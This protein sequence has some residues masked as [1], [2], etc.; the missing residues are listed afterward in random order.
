MSKNS[1]DV[2]V[3]IGA[4][5]IG[6]AIAR[7]VGAGR[8]VMLADYSEDALK[9][10]AEQ[11]RTESFEVVTHTVD[12]SDPADVARLADDAAALGPVTRL[13]QAAGLSPVMASPEQILKVDLYGNA[14]VLEEF[15]RVVAPGGSGVVIA[16][17]AGHMIGA[18]PAEA[19][20]ALAFAPAAELLELPFL[21]PDK[22]TDSGL[23]YA[24]SKRANALR[25]R[26][27][28][29]AWGSGARGSTA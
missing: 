8:T 13:A 29:L 15:A 14:L 11:L 22:V 7:R 17:M 10:A 1:K 23:A 2:A 26:G 3:I 20:H 28:A 24:V 12:I 16:S 19:D 5:G 18:F 4:G 9:E 27:A 25:V 6:L 21:A